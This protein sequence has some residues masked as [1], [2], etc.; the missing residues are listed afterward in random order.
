[1]IIISAIDNPGLDVDV[2]IVIMVGFFVTLHTFFGFKR[3]HF[4]ARLLGINIL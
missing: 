1:M 4:L 3:R 2:N